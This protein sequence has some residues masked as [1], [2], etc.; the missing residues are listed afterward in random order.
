MLKVGQPGASEKTEPKT[1]EPKTPTGKQLS[2]Q[3]LFEGTLL[4]KMSEKYYSGFHS[5]IQL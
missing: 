1:P 4:L 3:E 2:V 5:S